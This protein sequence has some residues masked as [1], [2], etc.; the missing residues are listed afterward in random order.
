MPSTSWDMATVSKMGH[1]IAV[2]L[3]MLRVLRKSPP[4]GSAPP[5]ANIARDK[6]TQSV[7]SSWHTRGP[8]FGTHHPQA[9][10]LSPGRDFSFTPLHVAWHLAARVFSPRIT[11]ESRLNL[12]GP[13]LTGGSLALVWSNGQ[14]LT[15]VGSH[16]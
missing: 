1:T 3:P 7:A 15:L 9:L 5:R 8:S 4:V 10:Y 16:P 2:G 6:A 14:A 12:P 13:D 11:L